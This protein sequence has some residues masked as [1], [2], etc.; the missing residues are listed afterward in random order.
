M[1][2][3]SKLQIRAKVLSVLS[4]IKANREYTKEALDEYIKALSAIPDKQ[5]MFD[6]FIKEFVKL[7]ADECDFCSLLIKEIVDNNYID[8]KVLEI[9]KSSSYSDEAKYKL[10][11]LLRIVGSKEDV[12]DLPNYFDNPAEMID[13]ETERLLEKA[14]FNPE[15]M[16]DFLD[17]IYTVN[18]RDKEILLFSKSGIFHILTSLLR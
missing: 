12:V 3:L 15:T 13:K 1:E 4:E 14:I 5:A 2:K 6:I 18:D 8:D 17:F 16:L 7:E 9:L 10:V 11:Q